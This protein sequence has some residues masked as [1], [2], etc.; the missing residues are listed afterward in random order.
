MMSVNIVNFSEARKNFKSVKINGQIGKEVIG[1]IDM[2]EHKSALKELDRGR[3]LFYVTFAG[4]KG[5]LDNKIF[6]RDVINA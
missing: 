4:G 2:P 6:L 3:L 5:Y 1:K